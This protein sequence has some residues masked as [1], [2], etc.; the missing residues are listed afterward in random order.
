[1]QGLLR[2]LQKPRPGLTLLILLILAAVVVAAVWVSRTQSQDDG[3][4]EVTLRDAEVFRDE[5]AAT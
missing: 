4:E 3:A 2:Q 5:A 1:M